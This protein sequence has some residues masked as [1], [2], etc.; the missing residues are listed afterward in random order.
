MCSIVPTMPSLSSRVTFRQL[1]YVL[2]VADAGTMTGAAEQLNVSQSAI[3]LAVSDLERVLGVQL[4]LRRKAKGVAP[5]DA[6]RTMLPE[7]RRL[8]AQADDLQ[9][10]ARSLGETIEGTLHLGC[11]PTLTPFVIP[12]V[13]REFPRRHPSVD[14]D[15]FEGSA[16]DL[17]QRLLDG[18]CEV[19]LMYGRGVVPDVATTRLHT[20]RPCVILPADHRLARH[21]DPIALVDLRDEPMVIPTMARG[22]DWFRSILRGAGIE[23]KVRFRTTTA[24]SVRSLV[25]SGAG[26][27]MAPHRPSPMTYAGPEVKYRDIADDVPS[28]DIVL[29]H[30]R[31]ARLTRRA[32]AFSHFCRQGLVPTA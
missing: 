17:Q 14:I 6:G 10:M 15:L 23:P 4:F 22:E 20:L 24:E 27:S 16:E 28:I 29:A 7:I 13:L 21:D 30:A 2:A 26:F 9:S 8:V 11:F 3:S 31:S 19:A 32:R 12:Q 5:T 25:A 1:E 18:R